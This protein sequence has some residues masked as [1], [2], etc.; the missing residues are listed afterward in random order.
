MMLAAE[1][2]TK[3]EFRLAADEARK[4]VDELQR[5]RQERL[6]GLK[7]L[8]IARTGP[9]KHVGSAFVL[10]PLPAAEL[11]AQAGDAD[12]QA[13]LPYLADELDPNLRRQS[14]IAAED[15]VLEALVA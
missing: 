2:V 14:E 11:A 15:K 6:D 4:Y 3:P 8:E 5:A 1:A 10:A 7:R 12:T 9:V 13:Q